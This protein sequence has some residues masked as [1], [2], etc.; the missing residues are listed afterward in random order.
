MISNT[1]VLFGITN[2]GVEEVECFITK[3]GRAIPVPGE[4]FGYSGYS[5]E[6]GVEIFW[7][8][9]EALDAGIKRSER[10]MSDYRRWLEDEAKVLT[11][12]KKEKESS[13]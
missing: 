4:K 2:K 11:N 8:K 1:S 9:N 6:I 13:K 10:R 3:T 5:L 12:L 7:L